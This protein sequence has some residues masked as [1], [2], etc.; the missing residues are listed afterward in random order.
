MPEWRGSR[1]SGCT[2]RMLRGRTC[3]WDCRRRRRRLCCRSSFRL[4]LRRF[5]RA[6][7]CSA[8]L[9]VHRRIRS[10][11]AAD[12]AAEACD[13]FVQQSNFI[14]T[15]GLQ[16]GS[17]YHVVCMLLCQAVGRLDHAVEVVQRNVSDF[18]IRNRFPYRQNI[19]RVR[20]RCLEFWILSNLYSLLS[21]R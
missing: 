11:L 18:E 9:L 14:V 4:A 19:E 20:Q 15:V 1:H 5:P 7:T 3:S 21:V 12:T 13:E 17:F 8:G 16:P 6:G 2:L 10:K